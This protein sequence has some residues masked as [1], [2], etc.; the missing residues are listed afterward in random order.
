MQ[1]LSRLN[2]KG[3]GEQ[4]ARPLKYAKATERSNVWFRAAEPPAGVRQPAEM[5]QRIHMPSSCPPAHPLSL[6]LPLASLFLMF[7]FICT[8]CTEHT[9]HCQQPPH[10]QSF[11]PRDLGESHIQWSQDTPLRFRSG[12]DLRALVSNPSLPF[13][14]R[15]IPHK[16]PPVPSSF[17]H[18]MK[19]IKSPCKGIREIR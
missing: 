13:P 1:G 19:T 15:V 10:P 6:L 5:L 2:V 12:L 3:L 7:P 4:R 16:P 14:S 17:I 8:P 11:P 18:E 9:P